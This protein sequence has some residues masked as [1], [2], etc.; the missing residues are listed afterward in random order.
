MN[1]SDGRWNV[2][3][4]VKKSLFILCDS[5]DSNYEME[6]KCS[7]KKILTHSVNR[8]GIMYFECVVID[9]DGQ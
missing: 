1:R 4:M 2:L 3:T 7:K 8:Y 6:A 5:H 9:L